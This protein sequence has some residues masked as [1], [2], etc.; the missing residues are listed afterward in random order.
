GAE[1]G[2]F[3]SALLSDRVPSAWNADADPWVVLSSGKLPTRTL[4]GGMVL[5]LLSPTPKKLQEMRK[6]WE[7]AV[8]KAH[9]GPGDLEAAWEKLAQKKK[10]LPKKGLLGTAPSLDAL[11]KK[12]F[13]SDQAKPNGSSIAFLAEYR[14]KSALFLGDA[15]PDVIATSIKRLC[16]EREAPRL[17]VDAVKVSHHGS[18]SNTSDAILKLLDCPSYLIS[19]NGDQFKH[20]D[21]ACIARILKIAAPKRMYFNYQSKFTKPWLSVECQAKYKYKAITRP[22]A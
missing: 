2:E 16:V 10:F 11:L 8:G 6:A 15:H 3:L 18:K 5:T 13:I 22:S 1:Q 14:E 4:Q 12:Q 19:T 9:I 17:K 21:K 7:A 20:P